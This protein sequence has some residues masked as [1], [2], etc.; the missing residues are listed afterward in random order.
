MLEFFFF[1]SEG[2]IRELFKIMR[3]H[4][5]LDPVLRLRKRQ[6]DEISREMAPLIADLNKIQTTIASFSRN[7]SEFNRQKMDFLGDTDK[8]A[9]FSFNMGYYQEM[10]RDS[11]EKAR[12]LENNLKPYRE[13]LSQA[14]KRRRAIELIRERELEKFKKNQAKT[15]QKAVEALTTRYTL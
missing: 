12:K 10:I 13:K 7:L 8:L 5:Q 4:F 11:K 1:F 9:N 3:F 6:E 15:E 2:V 14:F